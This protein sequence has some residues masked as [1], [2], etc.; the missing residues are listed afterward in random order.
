MPFGERLLSSIFQAVTPRTAGFNTANLNGIT[1]TGILLMIILMMIGGSSGSTA[2]G[3]K[4]TT[5]AVLFSS[6]L[7]VFGKKE[8]TEILKRR[9]DDDTVKNALSILILYLTL[10]LLGSAIIS[11]AEGLDMLTCM[12][13]TASAIATV[14]LTLGITPTLGVVSKIT[15][16]I[17]MFIGRIGGLT[18]VYAT[19]GTANKKASKLPLDKISVG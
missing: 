16:I 4:M 18:M 13:E 11:S 12:F 8:G 7:S 3:M 1:P 15:L 6:T 14:G 9:I 17:L 5:V 10:F 2:G 19:L